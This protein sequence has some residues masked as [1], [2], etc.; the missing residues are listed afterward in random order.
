MDWK[1]RLQILKPTSFRDVFDANTESDQKKR[2]AQGQQR[3][4]QDQ[5]KQNTGSNPMVVSEQPKVTFQPQQFQATQP[6]STLA[7][8]GVSTSS[9]QNSPSFLQRNLSTTGLSNIGKSTF[10]NTARIANTGQ[11]FADTAKKSIMEYPRQ[12]ASRVTGNKAASNA[13][14]FRIK[15]ELSNKLGTTGGIF[16]AG[17][18]FDETKSPSENLKRTLATTLGFAGEVA[19]VG[20]G[21]QILNQGYKIGSKQAGKLIA[22]GG[23]ASGAAN[24]GEQYLSTGKIDPKEVGV[25]TLFGG[26]LTG[27][28]GGLGAGVAKYVDMKKLRPIKNELQKQFPGI[29]GRDLNK[30]AKDISKATD[31]SEINKI[32]SDYISPNKSENEITQ[33][34][35]E[36]ITPSTEIGPGKQTAQT[37]PTSS[38][39]QQPNVL[40]DVQAAIPGSREIT[41]TNNIREKYPALN[42]AQVNDFNS[43][44]ANARTPEEKEVIENLAAVT[45]REI[46]LQTQTAQQTPETAIQAARTADA[47][48]LADSTVPMGGKAPIAPETAQNGLEALPANTQTAKD[49]QTLG[50]SLDEVLNQ[51]L[52]TAKPTQ[53]FDGLISA[54]DDLKKEGIPESIID[55]V[56]RSPDAPTDPTDFKNA[57]RREAGKTVDTASQDVNEVKKAALEA[58]NAGDVETANQLN[59]SLKDSG[60]EILAGDFPT[61]VNRT[62][63][64]MSEWADEYNGQDPRIA[65]KSAPIENTP[66]TP[67]ETQ[68]IPTGEIKDGVPYTKPD[69]SDW[70]FTGDGEVAD[71]FV[72]APDIK[73][74]N[75]E[76][77]MPFLGHLK[78]VGDNVG[79]TIDS[80]AQKV[81]KT[82]A[83]WSYEIQKANREGVNPPEWAAKIYNEQAGP[84]LE[85]ARNFGKV[86]DD[87]QLQN[88]YLPQRFA[89]SPAEDIMAGDSLI[90]KL[91]IKDAGFGL[92]RNNDIP[93]DEMDHSIDNLSSYLVKNGSMPYQKAIEVK[94]MADKIEADTGVRPSNEEVA[95]I[96]TQ[97][98]NIAFKINQAAKS[99]GVI[100]NALEKINVVDEFAE[101]GKKKGIVRQDLNVG[102]G[103]F[104]R[105]I[106]DSNELYSRKTPN[107][108][109]IKEENG[110]KLYTHA[111]E[112]SH[113][114][115]LTMVE[116]GNDYE[117]H[118]TDKYNSVAIDPEVK[119]QTIES[120]TRRLNN[121]D[122]APARL[123]ESISRWERVDTSD[124]DKTAAKNF[125]H[126]LDS[127]RLLRERYNDP[128]YVRELRTYA[129]AQADKRIGKQQM[130]EFLEKYNINDKQMKKNI[131][132]DARRMLSEDQVKQSA[133]ST[134]T[135]KA[136]GVVYTGALGYNPA[137]A[138]L[139]ILELKRAF[140][141]FDMPTFFKS[142]YKAFTDSTI[143]KRYGQAANKLSDITEKGGKLVTDQGIT[144]GKLDWAKPMAM[145]R[146][147]E[148]FKDKVFLHGLE[149]KHSD[150]FGYNKAVAVLDDFDKIAIKYGQKGSLGF[151]KGNLGRA[152]FQFMQY[153]IKET[154]INLDNA[155]KVIGVGQH[156]PADRKAAAKYLAKMGGANVALYLALSASLGY[157]WEM[158]SGLFNPAANQ[159]YVDKDAP[160]DVKIAARI[161][162][163]PLPDM[164]KDF[165]ISLRTEMDKAT[166]ESRPM[167]W[168]KLATNNLKKDAALLV[169][170]GNQIIN[171]TGGFITDQLRGYNENAKGKARFASTDSNLQKAKAVV[172]GRYQTP[173]AKEYFGSKMGSDLPFIGKKIK[174]EQ[175][176]PV[177]DRYQKE[178]E[179]STGDKS[180]Y[181]LF[182]DKLNGKSGNTKS[183]NQDIRLQIGRSRE[184]QEKSR[185]FYDTPEGKAWKEFNSKYNETTKKYESDVI[186]PEKWNK[187][188]SDKSK[189]DF[190]NLRYS[191]VKRNRDFKDP[192][193]PI[194]TNKWASRK[195]EILNMR[196]QYTGD[197]TEMKDIANATKPWYK[198]YMKDYIKYI[199]EMSN[200]KYEP[201]ED[202][203]VT[204]RVKEYWQLSKENPS[205]PE[206]SNKN[207][208]LIAKYYAAGP[209]GSDARKNFY[210]ENADSLSKEF[211]AQ[212]IEKWNWTNAMRDIEGA[213]PIPFDVFQNVTFG[214]EDDERKVAKELYYKLGNGYSKSNSSD[215][216]YLLSLLS[217]NATN[218]SPITLTKLKK[219]VKPAKLKSFA[220]TGNTKKVR[221][222]LN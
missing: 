156:T 211:Q 101:I 150:K 142:V 82:Y 198:E 177:G 64:P 189:S 33:I 78:E 159:T 222:R 181:E 29:F 179:K 15:N 86:V 113:A 161:P 43:K 50:T 120:A 218:A 31:E 112:T 196:S 203:D 138:M 54:T 70:V 96:I 160:L 204:P 146:A 137:S 114:D 66:S 67:M 22:Q 136:T 202:Y 69:G 194:F 213:E 90:N 55:K 45:Q 52:P 34:L 76:D 155:G 36:G 157:T 217:S 124:W 1:K 149:M 172:F 83:D 100:N 68:A 6:K 108:V 195:D 61:P 84:A 188:K 93:L 109:E 51:P 19:P 214:Y 88:W 28:I 115:E 174:G 187:V 158:V 62:P 126:D 53:A 97:E 26:A 12:V 21:V 87:D 2:L 117:K 127:K 210:K 165:Y 5:K 140:A 133:L 200:K 14:N 176:Y 79:K 107:G 59:N 25:S 147:T 178:I 183:R 39:T 163:G 38:T 73:T 81:G 10:G 85:Q 167:D 92:K 220:P 173:E 49:L 199:G 42:D 103:V 152:W 8:F 32:L 145:F 106:S 122:E 144:K 27:T 143:N 80:E 98:E 135:D 47:Q 193:D 216:K 91:D 180:T 65:P 131:N 191:A 141:Y 205:I 209:E 48:A 168:K 212:K 121:I 11:A 13:S 58:Y 125:A 94:K 206:I 23:L 197:D 221:I 105:Q 134:V 154:K 139:N 102:V 184:G 72:N 192:L 116:Q 57:V 17:T 219:A 30:V 110:F 170:G 132:Q 111:S 46:E 7:Q 164:A 207:H 148:N 77:A 182:R 41:P 75:I 60:D 24:I 3:Y 129:I 20:K 74:N 63:E 162:G 99:G 153:P 37:P 4:Y 35:D 185:A 215:K 44:L 186:S 104:K 118:F 16:N 151:N 208:P 123:D 40:A 9:P 119:T 130:I 95:S 89:D 71:A 18:V 166:E 171:K 175:Q 56:L 201:S 169:P 128:E 190:E